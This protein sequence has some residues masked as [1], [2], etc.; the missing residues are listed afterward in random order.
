MPQ[1]YP[2]WIDGMNGIYQLLVMLTQIVLHLALF[3]NAL[4]GKQVSMVIT[5]IICEYT[6][7]FVDISRGLKTVQKVSKIYPNNPPYHSFSALKQF[8]RRPWTK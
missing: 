4:Q 3:L 8:I 7:K 5:M 6:W 1:K 2:H